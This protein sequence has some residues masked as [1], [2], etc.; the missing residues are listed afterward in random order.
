M[1][2]DLRP[3][4]ICKAVFPRETPSRFRYDGEWKFTNLRNG[5]QFYEQANHF[6]RVDG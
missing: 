6:E 4:D 3:G 1:R 2:N 5:H